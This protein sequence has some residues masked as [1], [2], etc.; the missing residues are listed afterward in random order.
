MPSRPART[1]FA[2][3]DESYSESRPESRDVP[4][5]SLGPSSDLEREAGHECKES[6]KLDWDGPDDPENPQ[7]WPTYKRRMQVILIALITLVNNLAMTMFAPGASELMA[8][9]HSTSETLGSLTVSIYVVGYVV[10]SSV[11]APLSEMYGRLPIYSASVGL[12][13]AFTI[14]CAFA[15]NL[16]MFIAFRLLAGCAA[17]STLVL[18][19]G[20]LADVIPKK[21]QGRWMSLFV[22][23]PL[24]GPVIGPIAGGF[25][26]QAIGWRWIFRII[27]MAY[28][29]IAVL[30]IIFL[31][32][33][34]GAVILRRRAVRRG[35][36]LSAFTKPGSARSK[37]AS[38]ILRPIRLLIYSPIVLFLS[39]YAAFAFGLQFL[40]FTT[41]TDVFMNRYHWSVGVSGLAYVGLGVGMFAAVIAHTVYA[42]KIVRSRA[43]KNGGSKPEDRLPLMA[44]MAPALP[45]GMFWYGWSVDKT[46]HWIVPELATAVV[47]VGIVFIMMPQ[48]VYLV[49][50]FGAEAGASA[51]AANTFL[52]YVAGAFLPLAGPAMYDKLG[53]GWGNSLLGFIGLAFIPIPWFLVI[54]GER[55]RLNGRINV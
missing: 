1:H 52:R 42:E 53:L 13:A 12:Y 25:I 7:N 6:N 45:I 44:Y 51:L 41:F 20:T 10:G 17:S 35:Q 54:Y 9:F 19:G 15:T 33:T 30:C 22:L 29:A 49:Q 23:G 39:L 18:C 48:M 21:D 16:G 38:D 55:M 47:G 11:L 40:L 24:A 46:V 4:L 34:Y 28:A 3:P 36:D 5:Q 31:R 27:L 32:E 26:V 2:G 43:A 50:V 37:F 14:G 8:E